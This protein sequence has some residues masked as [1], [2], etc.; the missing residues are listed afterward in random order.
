M[1]GE[2]GSAVNGGAVNGAAVNGSAVNGRAVNGRAVNGGAVNGG[3][4]NGG[5]VNGGAVNGRAV[6]GR[7]VT[8]VAVN[9]G[10]VNG[11]AVNGGGVNGGAGSDTTMTPD[12][13]T[14]MT[15]HLLRTAAVLQVSIRRAGAGDAGGRQAEGVRLQKRKNQSEG[16]TP[17]G[18]PHSNQ[19]IS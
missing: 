5:A 18:P 19:N 12:M 6:N 10:A 9:G 7:A 17:V 4:V 3:A 15:N 1:L 2:A 14:L 16:S 13:R 8:A 11:G